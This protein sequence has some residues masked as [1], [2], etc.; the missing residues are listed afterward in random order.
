MMK[1]KELLNTLGCECTYETENTL[2]MN[3][4]SGDKFVASKIENGYKFYED[5]LKPNQF[6]FGYYCHE[7]P[8][9]KLLLELFQLAK[10]H[11]QGIWR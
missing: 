9:I 3:T 6:R 1:I 8:N 11:K 2:F 4:S 5:G 7:D 10:K